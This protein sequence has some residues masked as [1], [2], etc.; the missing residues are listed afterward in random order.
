[1]EAPPLPRLHARIDQNLRRR[2]RRLRWAIL[3]LLAG[4]I[5]ACDRQQQRVAE[6]G[7][8]TYAEATGSKFR[9]RLSAA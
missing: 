6:H 4:D 7:R 8:V 5:D 3:R 1:M 2:E 9:V